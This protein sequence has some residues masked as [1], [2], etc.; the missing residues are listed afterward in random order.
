MCVQTHN[1]PW[2][3]P[4]VV[5]DL[6]IIAK[7]FPDIDFLSLYQAMSANG[8]RPLASDMVLA[9]GV[10]NG[11]KDNFGVSTVP[12]AGLDTSTNEIVKLRIMDGIVEWFENTALGGDMWL[13]ASEWL[14]RHHASVFRFSMNC[15]CE[16][17]PVN[18]IESGIWHKRLMRFNASRADVVGRTNIVLRDSH[19]GTDITDAQVY[20]WE[21]MRK[22]LEALPAVDLKTGLNAVA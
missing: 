2:E 17:V 21:R 7:Y 10:I 4:A 1:L 12:F 19:L 6:P 8:F 16:K 14:K 11:P 5:T 18:L 3:R 9:G 13:Q 20:Y 22:A 15:S